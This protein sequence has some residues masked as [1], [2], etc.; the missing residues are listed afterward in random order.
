MHRTWRA[1]WHLPHSFALPVE[2]LLAQMSHTLLCRSSF[3][4]LL[5]AEILVS[6]AA[7]ITEGVAATGLSS[8]SRL[9]VVST[10]SHTYAKA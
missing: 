9:S 5:S 2:Q 10:V 8:A 3:L 7:T 1:L 4:V 6:N